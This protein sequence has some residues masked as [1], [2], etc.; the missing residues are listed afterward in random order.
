[1]RGELRRS[2]DVSYVE[3][4]GDTGPIATKVRVLRALTRL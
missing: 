2:Q 3:E 4:I 1:M